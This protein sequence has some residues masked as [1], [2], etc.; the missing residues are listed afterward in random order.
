M[1]GKVKRRKLEVA[2]PQMFLGCTADKIRDG[3]THF[4]E[5]YELYETRLW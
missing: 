5:L 2:L 4:L 3:S 1:F